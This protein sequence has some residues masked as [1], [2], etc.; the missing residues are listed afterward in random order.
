M[1]WELISSIMVITLP[2]DYLAAMALPQGF[3]WV[4]Q[5]LIFS[6]AGAPELEQHG[7]QL[8]CNRLEE[9]RETERGRGKKNPKPCERSTAF[10]FPSHKPVPSCIALPVC[11]ARLHR[12][13]SLR[14][15]GAVRG[16]AALVGGGLG[17]TSGPPSPSEYC[18][19]GQAESTHP[20][21]RGSFSAFSIVLQGGDAASDLSENEYP[22]GFG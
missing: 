9:G 13:L 7:R 18:L 3:P 10:P 11:P 21:P 17:G 14:G 19:P 1:S 16:D 15:S 22:D 8:R 4:L 6:V 5:Q 12:P 2:A 20:A